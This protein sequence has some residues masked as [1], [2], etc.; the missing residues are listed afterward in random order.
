MRKYIKANKYNIPAGFVLY[1]TEGTK[2]SFHFSYVPEE[3][4]SIEGGI[5]SIFGG[6]K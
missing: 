3:V 6:K 2:D 1:N 5:K 4:K